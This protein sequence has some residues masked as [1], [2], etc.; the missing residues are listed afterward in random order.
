MSHENINK[1]TGASIDLGHFPLHQS[2]F[3]FVIECCTGSFRKVTYRFLPEHSFYS[4]DL[5]YHIFIFKQNHMIPLSSISMNKNRDRNKYRQPAKT[6]CISR[7]LQTCKSKKFVPFQYAA[8][9]AKQTI[10][11][12]EAAKLPKLAKSCLKLLCLKT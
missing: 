2:L 3:S 10:L 1:Y 8:S 4:K 9:F 5:M 6:S 12:S 7:M 11:L